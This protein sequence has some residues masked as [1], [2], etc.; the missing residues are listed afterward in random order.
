MRTWC[1]DGLGGDTAQ[2]RAQIE[3]GARDSRWEFNKASLF[4][5][6]SYAA[7]VC[8]ELATCVSSVHSFRNFLGPALRS[9]TGDLQ[10]MTDPDDSPG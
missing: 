3:E 9:I 10:V 5:A 8:G 6:T 7:T 4:E 1:E 2:V